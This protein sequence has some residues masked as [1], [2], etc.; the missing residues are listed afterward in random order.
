MPIADGATNGRWTTARSSASAADILVR[1]LEQRAVRSSLNHPQPRASR[2]DAADEDEETRGTDPEDYHG[3]RL[4][5]ARLGAGDTAPA[6][7]ETYVRRLFDQYAGRYD[8]SLTQR[9]AY[10]G[11]ALLREAV[12]ALLRIQP[13]GQC[14]SVPC[15]I[16]AA[17]PRLPGSVSPLRRLARRRR[18][19]AG[20]DRSGRRQGSLRSLCHCRYCRCQPWG[21]EMQQNII[22]SSR[23]TCS[24]MN[25]LAGHFRQCLCPVDGMF[26]FVETMLTM[27]A[28]FTDA[29]CAWRAYVLN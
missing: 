23:P 11:P 7:T 2:R 12:E 1:A 17:A 21:D 29:R 24:S 3:A 15:W 28:N 5:L 22:S 13:N 26:A 18:S 10:R 6:M 9:L 8:V 20:H 25:D 4:Q 27:A 19:F 14:A 16:S